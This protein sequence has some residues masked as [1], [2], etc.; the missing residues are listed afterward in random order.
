MTD[1]RDRGA[2]RVKAAAEVLDLSESAVRRGVKSGQIPSV[3]IAGQRR[4]PVRWIR[5]QIGE[6]ESAQPKPSLRAL[7]KMARLVS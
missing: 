2:L 5:E 3:T 7:E 4:I 6:S 1:W